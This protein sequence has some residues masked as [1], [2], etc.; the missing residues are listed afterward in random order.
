MKNDE[1]NKR[2]RR[3]GRNAPQIGVIRVSSNPGPDA[4]DRLRR[5][6]AIL[7]KY[8]TKNGFGASGK[9][10]DASAAESRAKEED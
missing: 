10:E 1:Q 5:V 9:R 7:V 8:A 6:F 4:E 3:P 2:S